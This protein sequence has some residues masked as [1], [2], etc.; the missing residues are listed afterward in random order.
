MIIIIRKNSIMVFLLS[1]TIVTVSLCLMNY[2]VSGYHASRYTDSTKKEYL[3][4]VY[5]DEKKLIL[6]EN[7]KNI[8]QYPIASG[9]NEWPSPIGDWEIIEKGDWGEGFGGRWLGLNVIWGT[10]GIHGTTEESSIGGAHS[11]GCIRMFNRDIMELYDFVSVGTPVVISNGPFGP[12][13]T[14]FRELMPGDR[15]ADVLAIQKSLKSLGYFEGYES[16][17]YEDDL[18]NSLH[19]F[20]KDKNLDVENT[21]SLDDYTAMGFKEFE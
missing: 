19:R 2:M 11:H 9:T 14:G 15:G 1:F 16:G 6:L 8:R 18:K 20:Q 10:Y 5:I 4:Q 17:I 21:I 3:I 12:F 13:G 7:G